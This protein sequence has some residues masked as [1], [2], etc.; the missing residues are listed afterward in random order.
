MDQRLDGTRR[1]AER[2]ASAV[3]SHERELEGF[4]RSK[5]RGKVEE[6]GARWPRRQSVAEAHHPP[7]ESRSIERQARGY[8]LD[9]KLSSQGDR[10]TP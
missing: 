5:G 8:A 10:L 4:R 2:Q 3:A 1:A 9:P 7:T 6:N